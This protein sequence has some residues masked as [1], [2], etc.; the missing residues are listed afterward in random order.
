[1]VD[2]NSD[3]A[4]LRREVAELRGQVSR[5]ESESYRSAQLTPGSSGFVDIGSTIG[6]LTVSLQDV[7]PYANGSRV[8]LRSGNPTRATINRGELRIT[9]GKTDQSGA[10]TG[11]PRTMTLALTD[12]L[13]EGGWTAINVNLEGVPPSDLG[14]LRL[15]EIIATSI[16]LRSENSSP[17]P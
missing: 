1:M 7:R 6:T 9:Y 2:L 5:L 10:P 16:S 14:Y 8:R 15:T 4:I 17:A 12:E 13:E 3:V 11:E